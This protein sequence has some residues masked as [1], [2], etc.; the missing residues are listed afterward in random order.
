M[1]M[2]I[3]AY[4]DVT[5]CSPVEIFHPFGVICCLHHKDALKMIMVSCDG[6]Q[7]TQIID[8]VSKDRPAYVFR[9][10][11]VCVWP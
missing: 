8:N 7:C 5:P 6:T 10:L 11:S 2:H 1:T 3:T 9:A 4:L